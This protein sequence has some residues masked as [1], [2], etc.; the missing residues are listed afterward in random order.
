M[1][2]LAWPNILASYTPANHR[3]GCG[4]GS[5]RYARETHHVYRGHPD[6]PGVCV[7]TPTPESYR[8]GL[9]GISLEICTAGILEGAAIDFSSGLACMAGCTHLEGQGAHGTHGG[10]RERSE[11][12]QRHTLGGC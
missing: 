4:A 11:R 9:V 10:F 2:A 5:A 7:S 1:F 6:L 12:Y 3:L 8:G